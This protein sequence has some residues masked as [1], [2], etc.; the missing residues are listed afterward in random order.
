MPTPYQANNPL[1]VNAEILLGSLEAAA[2]LGLDL[3]PSLDKCGIHREQLKSPK[4]QMAFHKVVTFLEDVASR[5]NCP[6]FGFFVGKHQPPLRFGPPSQ[7]SKLSPDLGSAIENGRRYSLMNSQESLWELHCNDGYAFL[8]RHNRVAYEGALVQLHTL[9]ITLVRNAMVSLTAGQLHL[10]YVTFSHQR[11]D[12]GGLYERYFNAPIYF[13]HDFDGLVFPD[14]YLRQPLPTADA[15]LYALVKGYLDSVQEDYSIHA[16]MPTRV[17]QH[18]RRCLGTS[19]C[20]L[21]GVAQLL[22]QHPRAIQRE[23]GA[24]GTTF[25]Q[26]LLDV[27]Q[28]VAERYLRSSGIALADLADMLGYRNVSAF[29]RAFKNYR[30]VSPATW[31]GAI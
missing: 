14:S 10:S 4:G 16:D 12:V 30:G 3:T 19:V 25:R 20:N 15:E 8:K 23:L 31:R 6:A 21:E 27:R 22:D 29:S 26:Q 24:A 5:C 7:L 28:E 11:P 17:S 9:A 2:E 13:D 1:L 18:I